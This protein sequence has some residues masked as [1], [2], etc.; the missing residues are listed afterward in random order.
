MQLSK[1][2]TLAELTPS[3]TAKRLG[4]KNDPTPAH[5][6]CLKGLSVNILDKVREHF[7]KPIWVSSGYRSKAL[8]EVTPGSSA[9]SQHCSGEAADLDQDGRGT[10][11]TNKMV[12]DY[13]KDHLTFDQLIY[14]YGTDANPDWVHV[15]WESTGKQ[16]KQVLRCTRVNGKP[17]YTPYK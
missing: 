16:R 9:T 4:I 6:E 1:Y 17:V 11:V 15:S 3:G 13:I 8:N 7:G 2:F 10:G 12:F 5:L 14:E